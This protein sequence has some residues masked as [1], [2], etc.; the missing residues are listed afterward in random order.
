MKPCLSALCALFFVF[1]A[2]AAT[3]PTA[4]TTAQVEAW[5]KL[6]PIVSPGQTPK[7]YE[8]VSGYQSLVKLAT[9]E[10]IASTVRT[11]REKADKELLAIGEQ[12]KSIPTPGP[13]EKKR[14]PATAEWFDANEKINWLKTRLSPF[15]AK[16]G[17]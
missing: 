4:P 16:M 15:L 17:G 5:K 7:V 9:A 12:L 11:L 6:F 1:T 3:V 14:T 8:M 13:K 2:S 10:N